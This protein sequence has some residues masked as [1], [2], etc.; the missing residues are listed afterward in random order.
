MNIVKIG[1]EIF[2]HRLQKAETF[3]NVSIRESLNKHIIIEYSTI[4]ANM[5]KL[6]VLRERSH[7]YYCYIQE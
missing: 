5:F 6:I 1:E 4:L 7:F 2:I 3:R